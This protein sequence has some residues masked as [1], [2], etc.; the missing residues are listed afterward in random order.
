MSLFVL[1]L[2]YLYK[3][4]IPKPGPK[5]LE[6]CF[7]FVILSTDYMVNLEKV[8]WGAKKIYSFVLVD[9]YYLNFS[10]VLKYFDWKF[11]NS[12]V[13]FNLLQDYA[14]ASN[15]DNQCLAFPHAY[16]EA[17]GI[18]KWDLVNSLYFKVQFSSF[19]LLVSVSSWIISYQRPKIVYFS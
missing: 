1:W 3:G 15:T 13:S 4:H 7:Y 12:Y 14:V 6:F 19:Q 2:A 9:R 17:W 18:C 5:G 16:L 10:F 11:S 8:S